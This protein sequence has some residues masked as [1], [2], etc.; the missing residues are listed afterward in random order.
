[1]HLLNKNLQN[2]DRFGELMGPMCSS[3][4]DRRWCIANTHKSLQIKIAIS[5]RYSCWECQSYVTD[6]KHANVFR[7]PTTSY[8]DTWMQS[9]TL[10]YDA[11]LAFYMDRSIS[12]NFSFPYLWHNRDCSSEGDVWHNKNLSSNEAINISVWILC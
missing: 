8:W 6:G 11:M 3:D 12:F 7:F 4:A 10:K 2:S 1:M 9:S 5:Y